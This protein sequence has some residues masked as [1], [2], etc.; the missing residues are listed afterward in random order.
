MAVL[1]AAFLPHNNFYT[2]TVQHA[3]WLALLVLT[4]GIAVVSIMGDLVESLMKRSAGLKDSSNLLPGHGGILD[5][6]DSLLPVLPL[7]L[8]ATLWMQS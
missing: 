2:Q 4:A 6:I 8:A 5:L 3:G 1:G 7:A